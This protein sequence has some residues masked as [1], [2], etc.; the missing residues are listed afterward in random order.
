[1]ENDSE[2]EEDSEADVNNVRNSLIFF[3]YGMCIVCCKFNSAPTI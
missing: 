3:L 2:F 1:M